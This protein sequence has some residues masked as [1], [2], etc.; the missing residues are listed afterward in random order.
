MERDF[1]KINN[2]KLI[3]ALKKRL[4]LKLFDKPKYGDIARIL[5]EGLKLAKG[6][7]QCDSYLLKIAFPE[8]GNV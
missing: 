2:K 7:R 5:I 3:F 1:K 8:Y 4:G 6:N